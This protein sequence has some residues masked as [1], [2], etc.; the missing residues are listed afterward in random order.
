MRRLI[1]LILALASIALVGCSDNK[2]IE[3]LNLTYSNSYE[4]TTTA[5]KDELAYGLWDGNELD[6]KIFRAANIYLPKYFISGDRITFKLQGEYFIEESYPSRLK[7]A[8]DTAIFDVS[9]DFARVIKIKATE[10]ER[11]ISENK[12]IYTYNSMRIHDSNIIIS[13][14]GNFI[15]FEDNTYEYLYISLNEEKGDCDMILNA[16]YGL[17][18]FDPSEINNK[19]SEINV[20]AFNRPI[21][22]LEDRI[23]EAKQYDNCYIRFN[24]FYLGNKNIKA[25]DFSFTYN[26]DELSITPLYYNDVRDIDFLAVPLKIGSLKIDINAFG[27]SW[28]LNIRVK[29]NDNIYNKDIDLDKYSELK[30][31]MD[32]IKYHE[33]KNP[34]PGLPSNSY[35]GYFEEYNASYKDYLMDSCYY[36]SYFPSAPKSPIM[37][38]DI[39]IEGERGSRLPEGSAKSSIFNMNIKLLQID[40]GCTKPMD[41]VVGAYYNM[42]RLEDALKFYTIMIK[43]LVLLKYKVVEP[44]IYE[45]NGLSFYMLRRGDSLSVFFTDDKYLY[46]FYIIYDMS[47]S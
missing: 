37:R 22:Y 4:Y 35:N 44:I 19:K 27:F 10:I 28:R 1:G 25:S 12:V 31:Y 47:K 17:Y 34:Y 6:D 43:D 33:F 45:A 13:R 20:S 9:F 24:T 41:R 3:E 38:R 42:V 2:N 46:S 40:P 36:P 14:D 5:S 11:S 7:L 32:G 23:L 21:V 30:S 8:K 15:P 26:K 16:P 39:R 18:S 29:E